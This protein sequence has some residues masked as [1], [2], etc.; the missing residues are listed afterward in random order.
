MLSYIT[1]IQ[2]EFLLGV[3]LMKGRDQRRTVHDGLDGMEGRSAGKQ[4]ITA[5]SSLAGKK[6]RMN[7]KTKKVHPSR[8]TRRRLV[9][10]A[11]HDRRTCQKRQGKAKTF[12]YY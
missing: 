11:R 8:K 2:D 5:S 7:W 10:I 4:F 6:R 12:R 1:L 9:L 3:L